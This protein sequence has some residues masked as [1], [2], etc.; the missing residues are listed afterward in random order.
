MMK[1]IMVKTPEQINHI[2]EA[3]KYHNELLLILR[4]AAKA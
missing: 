1:K 4:K 2:R 3:G